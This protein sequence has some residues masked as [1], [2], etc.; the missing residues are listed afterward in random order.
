MKK[1]VRY[2]T[3]LAIIFLGTFLFA[4]KLFFT[5]SLHGSSQYLS[6]ALILMVSL[7]A[8]LAN[9]LINWWIHDRKP[10]RIT[11]WMVSVVMVG[12]LCLFLGRF[13]F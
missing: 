6:I 11:Q 2:I 10:K 12:V 13:F 7:P 3:P 8:L 4:V 1:I 5:D 9:A